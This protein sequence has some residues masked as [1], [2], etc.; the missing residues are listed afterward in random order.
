MLTCLCP[1]CCP[2]SRLKTSLACGLLNKGKITRK[3]SPASCGPGNVYK[4]IKLYIIHDVDT[5][6]APGRVSTVKANNN[7]TEVNT[8]TLLARYVHYHE[9][10]LSY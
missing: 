1:G 6:I 2:T 7:G 9:G 5:G 4:K 3:E 10:T 8:L